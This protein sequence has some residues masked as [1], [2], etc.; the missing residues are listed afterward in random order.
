MNRMQLTKK[1]GNFFLFL[2]ILFI[3]T[4]PI[5]VLGQQDSQWWIE[6]SGGFSLTKPALVAD[7]FNGIQGLELQYAEYYHV[8]T[9]T[10]GGF[11][12][13]IIQFPF[14]L[15]VSARLSPRWIL[16]GG[17]DYGFGGSTS[18]KKFEFLWHNGTEYHHHL[19]TNKISFFMPFVGLEYQRSF[20][21]LYAHFGFG[22]MFFSSTSDLSIIEPGYTQE[23]SD[24]L[25]VSGW[26]LG[27]ELGSRFLFKWGK[28]KRISIR[29]GY[30]FLTSGSFRGKKEI[31]HSNSSGDSVSQT[32]EGDLFRFDLDPYGIESIP[33]WDLSG[34]SP[35]GPEFSNVKNSGFSLSL[36]RI[37]VGI[38]FRLK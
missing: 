10:P 14:Q 12:E 19:I 1:Y 28:R 18:D 22:K 30:N 21:G 36:L 3:L 6:V 34:E 25:N 8:A 9:N 4:G 31:S 5:P 35:S 7:R 32:I 20:W 27:L 37:M 29:I 23:N 33:Y 24:V 11:N 26:G 15:S 2:F 17:L 16:K 13:N 38:S